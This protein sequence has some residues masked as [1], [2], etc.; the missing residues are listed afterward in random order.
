MISITNYVLLWKSKDLSDKTIKL[1]ATS[2]NSLTPT[3][4]YYNESKIRVKFTGS[5][6]KQDEVTFNHGKVV[7]IN[8]VYEL[9][10]SSS[11]NS[12]PAMKNCLFNAVTLTKNADIDKY[13]YSGYRI[14][15]DRRSS[16]S[17]PVGGFAI[18]GVC[19]NSS[20]HIDNKGKRYFN[21]WKRTNTR[22]RWAF[23]NCRKNVFN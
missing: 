22:I 13:R 1:P 21:S 4:N 6:W 16:F 5:C 10:A 9:G 14:G 20:I 18:F 2:N 12:D 3:L 15:F 19:M 23:I 8:I 11:S 7:N 17:F